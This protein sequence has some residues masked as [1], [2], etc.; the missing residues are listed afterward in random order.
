MDFLTELWLPIG[1]ASVF[2]FVASSLLHMIL[3]IHRGDFKKLPG[4]DAILDAMRAH[5]VAADNYMFPCPEN[6]KDM[7]SPEIQ[8]KFKTGPAGFMYVYPPGGFNMGK[9]LGQWFAYTILVSIFVAYV[10]SFSLNQPDLSYLDIFRL[11][12]TVAFL[13]YGIGEITNSIWKG[14]KWSTTCKFL[15][16]GLVYALVTAGAF[17]WLWP[18][19]S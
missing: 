9:S 2:V 1:L 4:E 18:E 3:P 14:A 15:F 16:D 7:G 12:G 5:N 19:A 13:A 17:G 8:Q 6:M 10:A 11:T